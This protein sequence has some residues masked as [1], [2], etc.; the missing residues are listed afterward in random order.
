M[1]PV[2]TRKFTELLQ[3]EVPVPV[4]LL[5]TDRSATGTIQKATI[6]TFQKYLL[7]L[8]RVSELVEMPPV[9][10][11][12]FTE[13]LQKE[14][15]VPV[16]LL[17]TGRNATGTVRNA[18]NGIRTAEQIFKQKTKEKKNKQTKGHKGHKTPTHIRVLYCKKLID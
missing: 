14:V 9:P 15:P 17:G 4:P 18:T 10:T 5:G 3:K 6:K 7:L 13:P 1:P 16:P 12:K 2:R 8:F 11:R